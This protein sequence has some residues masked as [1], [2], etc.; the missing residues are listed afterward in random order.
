M[1]R[2]LL[3]FLVGLSLTARL[4]AAP[5]IAYFDPVWGEP[6]K[7]IN[8]YGLFP[9]AT[10]SVNFGNI[11]GVGNALVVLDTPTQLQVV[12]PADALSGPIYVYDI[13]NAY[14]Y[15]GPFQVAPLV[16]SFQPN[17]GVPGQQVIIDGVNFVNVFAPAIR[18]VVRI[19]GLQAFVQTWTDTQ[20]TVVVPANATTGPISFATG[21]GTNI[22]GA[23]FYLPPVIESFEP[24]TAA[25]GDEV[26]I[27]GPNMTDA[28]AVRFTGAAGGT[29]GAS[30]VV[31]GPSNIVATVPATVGEGPIT[32]VAPAGSYIS[33]PG[34]PF[35]VLPKI[36]QFV[37]NSGPPG[38]V[39]KMLGSGLAN[40]VFVSFGGR[41]ATLFTNILPTRVDAVV[42]QQAQTGP[43]TIGTTTGTN[44]STVLF[45]V[46]PSIQ[47][48]NPSRGPPGTEVTVT[49]LNFTNATKVQFGGANAL[50][51]VD[52]NTQLHAT[53]PETALSGSIKI[54]T[55]GGV[56]TSVTPFEVT[57]PEPVISSFDPTQGPPGTVVQI[58]GDNFTGTTAVAFGGKPATS[59]TPVSDTILN[60]VVPANATTGRI[61][62]TNPAGT[63]TSSTDF[64][65]G[66]SADL[67]I[68]LTA[69]PN[70]PVTGG[71]L[72]YRV[73]VRN[74]GPLP[75]AAV[76]VNFALPNNVQFVAANGT[77]PGEVDRVG[78]NLL[79]QPGPLANGIT[80]QL[81]VDVVPQQ[82]GTL[83]AT[84]HVSSDTPDDTP[85][86]N[87]AQLE[88]NSG[89][90]TL[91]IELFPNGQALLTWPSSAGSYLL[92]SK[93]N[94]LPGS[95]NP[96]TDE[97]VEA[98]GRLELTI[99]PS[100]AGLYYRL[101]KP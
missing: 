65:V 30:F 56:A 77:P 48:F 82:A 64:F 81:L 96:V 44:T 90:V 67:Q 87:S 100:G 22:T 59:F 13:S 61:T 39:V 51:T 78:N 57:G 28:T 86:N 41:P 34:T 5:Q 91:T 79:Y 60:A 42:P 3:L 31:I 16:T 46:P 23:N 72:R 43:V 58:T 17:K 66:G 49:G 74:A 26:Q 83:T 97:P 29:V 4:V 12:V 84:A 89:G 45:Y 69:S 80:A 2:S 7:V 1:F 55:P 76:N 21:A 88:L 20:A 54:T 101:R 35:R 19:N 47:S 73:Q 95:W 33:N 14:T 36:D 70:P 71:A 38:T 92:E 37:P 50:F 68:T 24:T 99:T 40:T 25:V 53:V 62:I 15:K 18:P 98:D 94:L 85:A 10:K 75:A 8:I 11:V 93:S 27:K 32:V 9:L 52:A 6:G 63:A